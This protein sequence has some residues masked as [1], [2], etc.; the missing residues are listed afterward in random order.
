VFPCAI[1]PTV[2]ATNPVATAAATFASTDN[3]IILLSYGFAYAFDFDSGSDSL[4]VLVAVRKHRTNDS[5]LHLVRDIKTIQ[6]L[7]DNNDASAVEN[8]RRARH[9]PR[10]VTRRK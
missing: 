2:K 9:L 6:W 10:L 7:T 1:T 4:A 3:F 5:E 8:V